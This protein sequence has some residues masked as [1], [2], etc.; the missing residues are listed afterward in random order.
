MDRRV[1]RGEKDRAFLLK[2]KAEAKAKAKA[3]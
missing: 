1:G 2:A 3:P